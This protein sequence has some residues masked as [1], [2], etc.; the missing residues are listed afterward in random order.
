MDTYFPPSVC[1]FFL[2]PFCLF[3]LE[4][5][6][7]W[8]I[9]TITEITKS[10]KVWTLASCRYVDHLEYVLDDLGHLPERSREDKTETLKL[11][12]NQYECPSELCVED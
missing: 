4:A 9:K 7:D 5:N 2:L 11:K 6:C 3:F 8:L 1:L 12:A 10:N